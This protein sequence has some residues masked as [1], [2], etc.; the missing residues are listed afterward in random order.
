MEEEALY[1]AEQLDATKKRLI[2]AII[3]LDEL[4]LKIA[5]FGRLSAPD[6]LLEEHSLTKQEIDWLE[7]V[8]AQYPKA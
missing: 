3:R 6:N 1:I 5:C 8:I 2:R 4:E 7:E